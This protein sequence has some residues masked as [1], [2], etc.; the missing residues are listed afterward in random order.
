MTP[1]NFC[2]WLQGYFELGATSI[3]EEQCSVIKEHLNLVFKKETQ[4]KKT[5]SPYLPSSHPEFMVEWQRSPLYD[6]KDYPM[7]QYSE[8]AHSC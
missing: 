4:L 3:T 1:K 7:V 8:V 6:S 2:Y 5:T